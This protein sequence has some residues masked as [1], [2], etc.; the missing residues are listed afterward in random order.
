MRL[1]LKKAFW[2][3]KCFE[4][5]TNELKKKVLVFNVIS[6]MRGKNRCNKD[7]CGAVVGPLSWDHKARFDS[8]PRSHD[9]VSLIQRTD[10]IVV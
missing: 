6:E 5:V 9:V 3:E 4:V 1:T 7:S 2:I 8:P 10:F